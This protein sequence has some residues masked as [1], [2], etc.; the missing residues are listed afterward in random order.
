M[1]PMRRRE[2]EMSTEEATALFAL[3][4]T[5]HLASTLE[6]GTP[7]FRTLHS[8]VD[9]GWVVFHSAPKGEK[10]SLIGRVAVVCSEETVA[11][12]PS[13]FF[14]PVKACPAT[15]YYRSVQVQGLVEEIDEPARKARVLQRLM[16]KLQP[17]GGYLPISNP[18]GSYDPLY[19]PAVR[20]LLVAG[21]RLQ[22]L[23][24]KAK[25]AQNRS[26][27]EL[28][29]LLAS[30]WQRGAAGDLRALEMIRA[31]NP[32]AELPDFLAA[33]EGLTLHVHLEGEATAREAAALVAAAGAASSSAGVD[34]ASL[35]RAHLASTGWVGARDADGALVAT[36]RV[37]G[38]GV[39][40]ARLF[41]LA[42]VPTWEA[43]G[44]LAAITRLL[45]H[46]PAARAARWIE[47]VDQAHRRS[48]GLASTVRGSGG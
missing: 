20:G 6:D 43:S 37:V 15:T 26:P 44:A 38:D 10:T 39:T 14:D 8:V 1:L 33:P 32:A 29:E 40:F 19:K 35:A 21:V 31:A 18:D 2:F 5:M 16:E 13:T 22:D 42:V 17:E 9:D 4:P 48:T 47:Q 11:T 28:G 25:L 7:V 3:L 41:D 36:G 45:R 46:H 24:G 30:L 27:R 34:E 23:A 12:V